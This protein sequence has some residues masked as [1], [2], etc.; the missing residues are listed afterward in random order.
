MG[1]I[2]KTF[3]VRI[4]ILLT[5]RTKREVIQN[6]YYLYKFQFPYS[7]HSEKTH[8]LNALMIQQTLVFQLRMVTS[9]VWLM[10]LI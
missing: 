3:N 9:G 5:S 7:V 8:F 10:F 4:T 2:N 1:Y 6:V